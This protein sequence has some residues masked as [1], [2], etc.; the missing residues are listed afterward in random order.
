MAQVQLVGRSSSH[1]TRVARIMA[2][3]LGVGVELVPVQEITSDDPATF[4]GNPALK[5]PTLRLGDTAVFGTENICRTLAELSSSQAQVVW[6]EQ[7]RDP[8]AR[9][10]QELVWHAMAAQVQLVMGTVVAKLPAENVYFA[11]V[12]AGFMGALKWLDANWPAVRALLPPARTV[13][14]LEVTLFCLVEHLS[15]R[16]TIPTGLYRTLAA[17]AQEFAQRPSARATQYAFDPA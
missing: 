4:G 15:F 2:A 6:P 3:E 1:F 7:L 17:F 8:L 11:K 14:L 10:A 12:R 16:S 5:I 13:S 9:N